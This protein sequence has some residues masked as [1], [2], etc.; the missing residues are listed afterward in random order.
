MKTLKPRFC[1]FFPFNSLCSFLDKKYNK[2]MIFLA[3]TTYF[4]IL[5]GGLWFLIFSISILF[6]R[7]ST[8]K[9]IQLFSLYSVISLPFIIFAISGYLSESYVSEKSIP[10]PSYIY[11]YIRQYKM[12]LPFFGIRNFYLTGCLGFFYIL[13]FY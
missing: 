6:E 9:L 2:T 13:L 5:I 7:I 12:V 10:E 3:V 11:S 8:K 1:L 4:H